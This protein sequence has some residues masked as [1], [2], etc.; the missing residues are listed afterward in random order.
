MAGNMGI[1]MKDIRDD[2][3]EYRVGYKGATDVA[4]HMK[5][6]VVTE[7][8]G[9]RAKHGGP[10]ITAGPYGRPVFDKDMNIKRSEWEGEPTPLPHSFNHKGN[11]WLEISMK[12]IE[13]RINHYLEKGWD[14][15]PQNE[16][17]GCLIVKT[18]RR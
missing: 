2:Y 10:P 13:R 11:E 4:S 6:L 16:V 18:S 1:V 14:S 3:I 17:N 7:G 9:F 12:H 8:S 15:I 5:A